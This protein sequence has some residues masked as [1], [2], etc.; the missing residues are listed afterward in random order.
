MEKQFEGLNVL[1]EALKA[2]AK[3]KD[4]RN[5]VDIIYEV[6]EEIAR[7]SRDFS[8]S[9]IGKLSIERGGLGAGGIQN[10]NGERY[11]M[12]IAAFKSEFQPS[13][14]MTKKTPQKRSEDWIERI[15]DHQLKFLVKDL[16]MTKKT[17]LRENSLIRE[18]SARDECAPIISLGSPTT[19]Q[20]TNQS[21]LTKHEISVLK[22]IE[23]ALLDSD[24]LEKSGLSLGDRGEVRNS[25][26]FTVF[27]RGTLQL[28]QN[29]LTLDAEL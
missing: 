1:R 27:P 5:S 17:L 4:S 13:K 15:E 28:V 14:N 6:C 12:L 21:P 20:N 11:R 2:E 29:L 16:A 24:G 10:K 19:E 18:Y 9:N 26:G 22:E 23:Q 7:G 8:Y 25:A 3:R